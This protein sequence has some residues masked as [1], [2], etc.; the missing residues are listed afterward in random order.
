MVQ[1]TTKRQNT[2]YFS[3]A[4]SLTARKGKRIRRDSRIYGRMINF[5]KNNNWLRAKIRCAYAWGDNKGICKNKAD[6]LNFVRACR[7]DYLAFMQ[8]KII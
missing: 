6:A 1:H 5:I 8:E 7:K 4:V 3:V 2:P